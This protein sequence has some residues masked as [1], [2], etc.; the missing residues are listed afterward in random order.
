VNNNV[1]WL[2]TLHP[3]KAMSDKYRGDQIVR[4]AMPQ[5]KR[6]SSCR[7]VREW[8]VQLAGPLGEEKLGS[9]AGLSSEGIDV[10]ATLMEDGRTIHL[11]SI[12]KLDPLADD[13]FLWCRVQDARAD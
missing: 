4:V 7:W 8:E 1:K 10:V 9:L 6:D 5:W 13:V 12:T 11:M 2:Q 3:Q